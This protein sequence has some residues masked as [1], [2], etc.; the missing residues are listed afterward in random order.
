MADEVDIANAYIARAIEL[1]LCKRQQNTEVKEGARCCKKCKESI[2]P[3][4]R[5]LGFELCIECAEDTER[6]NALFANH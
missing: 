4:R 1:E 3:V 6:R 2:P 5:K